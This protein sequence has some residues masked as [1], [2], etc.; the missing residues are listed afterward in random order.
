M[1]SVAHIYS[2]RLRSTSVPNF[3]ATIGTRSVGRPPSRWT[4][5]IV[6]TAGNCWMRKAE[7]RV[8]RKALGK[9]YAQQWANKGC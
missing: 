2:S 8:L 5:D 4:D 6:R 1:S 3:E 7:D 9:A